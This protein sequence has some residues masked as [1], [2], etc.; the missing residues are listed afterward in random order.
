M[1]RV[2]KVE[3]DLEMERTVRKAADAC[4]K[5]SKREVEGLKEKLAAMEEKAD[6][7]LTA[8]TMR[9]VAAEERARHETERA[10]LAEVKAAE[11]GDK[12]GSE[13][14]NRTHAEKLAQTL[15]RDAKELAS[16][17]TTTVMKMGEKEKGLKD[18]KE[19]SRV[20]DLSRRLLAAKAGMSSFE[21]QTMLRD[22]R[23]FLKQC[24][25]RSNLSFLQKMIDGSA[26]G[27]EVYRR[28]LPTRSELLAA[29]DDLQVPTKKANTSAKR[30]HSELD[31]HPRKS[32]RTRD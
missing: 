29:D 32:H 22:I 7:T 10:I 17:L 26:E 19:D 5:D 1:G 25:C 11:F 2:K 4:A 23:T 8:E 28:F 12:Y 13:V 9:R 15:Q 16:T 20:A 27:F 24:I 14:I 3:H 21:S 31:T 18:E 30:K 6:Q